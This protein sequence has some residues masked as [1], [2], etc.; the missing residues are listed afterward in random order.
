MYR[1]ADRDQLVIE[2]FLLPFGGHLKSDNRWIKQAKQIPWDFIEDLYEK[3]FKRDRTDGRP[4][5]SARIA[6][7]SLY[8][9]ESENLTDE[10]TVEFI[11][12]NPYVQCFLGLLEFRPEPLFDSSMMTYFRKR[13]SNDDMS[14][15]NEETYRR[16]NLSTTVNKS[17]TSPTP[18]GNSDDTASEPQDSTAD[19]ALTPEDQIDTPKDE[20]EL[21]ENQEEPQPSEGKAMTENKGELVLDATAAP[22]DIRFPTD[23][24]LLNECRENVEQMI[25]EIWEKTSRSGHKT[26]YS[27][28]K[29]RKS[30]LSVAKQRKPR[31]GKIKKAIKEQLYFLG[32]ALESLDKILAEV[33]EKALPEKR[34]ERLSIIRKVLEQQTL[35]YDKP[36]ESIP[37]RIVNLR[38]PH[39]RPIVRGKAGVPTEFGQKLATSIV[40]GYTFIDVQ[41]FNNFNEGITLIASVEKYRKRHGFYPKAVLADTIYRNRVNR[42]YCKA[43]GIRLS[44]PRLGRPKADEEEADRDQAHKDSCA[45]NIV[46]SRNGIAKRRY[47]LNRIMSVLSESALTEASMNVF[48]MNVAHLLRVLLRAFSQYRQFVLISVADDLCRV[49]LVFQ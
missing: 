10:R 49:C 6:F 4:P 29:A 47:G 28:K 21:K 39:V 48:A 9:K 27:R 45:R 37:D 20:P 43:N 33:G 41:S 24:S 30:Y 26:T 42:A 2:E 3:S 5:I 44:G 36:R 32:C 40:S 25:E 12:E 34:L 8:I 7:G 17:D 38:Q 35:H 46:E 11:A 13:F 1:K 22:A 14:A 15:I 19:I 23:L 31:S 16:A 18:E